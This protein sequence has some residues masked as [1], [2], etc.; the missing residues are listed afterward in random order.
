M[1]VRWIPSTVQSD[2]I[3]ASLRVN[4]RCASASGGSA[5][6]GNLR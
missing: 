4:P 3:L 6:G 5:M 2:Q 1:P